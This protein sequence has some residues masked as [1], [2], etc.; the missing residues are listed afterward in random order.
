MM[1]TTR[2]VSL[3][4]KRARERQARRAEARKLAVSLM[5]RDGTYDDASER[6]L[7]LVADAMLPVVASEHPA[8]PAMRIVDHDELAGE[9]DRADTSF[10]GIFG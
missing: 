9:L 7:D 1:T 10:D 4:N 8:P 5:V 2:F 3:T 6:K